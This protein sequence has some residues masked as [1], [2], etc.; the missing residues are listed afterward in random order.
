MDITT[1]GEPFDSPLSHV[2]DKAR[3]F[4]VVVDPDQPPSEEFLLELAGR[5]RRSFRPEEDARRHR[6]LRRS[7]SG[8]NNVIRSL[9]RTASRLRRAR[10]PRFCRRLS[11]LD[12][13]AVPSRFR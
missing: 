3:V 1:L 8:L 7:V 4:N 9:V 10:D 5:A 11:G 12:P 6:H 2:S 13:M